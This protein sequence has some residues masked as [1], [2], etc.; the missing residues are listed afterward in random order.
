VVVMADR[1]AS[2]TV[3]DAPSATGD[4]RVTREQQ[5]ISAARTGWPTFA[6]LAQKRN[7]LFLGF[8]SGVFDLRTA[9][10]GPGGSPTGIDLGKAEGQRTMIGQSLEQT[11][12]RV[13]ARPVAGIVMLSDGR[14]ADSPGRSALRQL[15]SRQIPVYTVPLGSPTPL[16]D[17]AVGRVDSPSAAF[18]G[19]LVPVSV[20]IER[21]GG[22]GPGIRGK[23]QLVDDATEVVLDERPLEDPVQP[24]A[25]DHVTLT[26]HPE[27][28]GQMSWSVRLVLDTPDL[29]TANNRAAVRLELVDRPIRVVY[30]DGYPRWEYRYLKNLL[31][32]EKSIK[33]S[34][35]LLAPD[36]RY[37]Q[38]GTDPLDG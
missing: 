17:L 5:L 11:L 4:A 24:N 6:A 1:S 2:M 16:V 32:R 19:D 21:L 10:D 14:S 7:V 23:V 20:D 37:L 13:A 36:R 15:E 29:T 22:T 8:D 38:E 27:Q 25:P 30:F 31:V 33:S 12:H 3:A 28:P 18:V 9:N 35:L 34:T 26:A